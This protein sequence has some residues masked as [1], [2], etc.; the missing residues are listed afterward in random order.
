MAA[1]DT[2]T[3]SVLCSGPGE[4]PLFSKTKMN[5]AALTA[6]NIAT[7]QGAAA[8]L[9]AAQQNLTAGTVSGTSF[10]VENKISSSYPSVPANR[11]QKW[12]VTA[13]NG[14]QQIY[15]YTIPAAKYDLTATPPDLQ[16]DGVSA[17]LNSTFWT[18][19]SNA[20]V[21]IATDRAGGAL[22]IVRAKLG[23]R[24]R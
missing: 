16:P 9:A 10:A 5:V 19:W 22:N 24:R 11:G 12:I 13:V 17:N 15:T 8:T 7:Q 2:L 18:D 14:A 23:G 6:G 1:V 21:A 3:I 4:Q 20:F